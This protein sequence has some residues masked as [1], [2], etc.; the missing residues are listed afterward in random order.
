MHLVRLRFPSAV[1]IGADIPGIGKENVQE[2]IHA[3]TLFSMLVNTYA[4]QT[5]GDEKKVNAFCDSVRGMSSAFPL[6]EYRR[7]AFRYFLPRPLTDPADF[8]GAIGDRRRMKYG[9][10]VKECRCID[11]DAFINYVSGR[12]VGERCFE[13]AAYRDLYRIVIRPKHAN[14]R[15]TGAA[16]IYHVGDVFFR[17][18]AGLYFIFDGPGPDAMTGVLSSLAADGM[19]GRRSPGCGAF[20]F[21]IVDLEDK[22]PQLFDLEGDG[23]HVCLAPFSPAEL[24]ACRPE[25]YALLRRKG[26]T[27]STTRP[28]Q[29]KR[30]T[31]HMFAEGSVFAGRVQGQLVPVAPEPKSMGHPV[32]RFGR[33]LTVACRIPGGDS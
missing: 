33:P 6:Q 5:G 9:K 31:C 16:Q 11:L 10:S 8:T 32:Y 24:A 3:D 15:L 20:T 27:F 17:A 29:Y 2:I 14:D 22:W 19:A 23:H 21:E 1:H 30:K 25:A 7:N 4:R 12:N 28:G 26:W 18:D 13:E